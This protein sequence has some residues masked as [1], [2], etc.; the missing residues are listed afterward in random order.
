MHDSL[1]LLQESESKLTYP[2]RNAAQQVSKNLREVDTLIQSVKQKLQSEQAKFVQ[3]YH[4]ITRDIENALRIPII[5]IP[6]PDIEIMDECL[7]IKNIRIVDDNSQSKI[8]LA[9]MSKLQYPSIISQN[10]KPFVDNGKQIVRDLTSCYKELEKLYTDAKQNLA[11]TIPKES[12]LHKQLREYQKIK[13][14]KKYKEE[15]SILEE[16]LDNEVQKLGDMISKC[17]EHN[18]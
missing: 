12:E 10:T 7:V 11:A 13:K 16:Y 4:Q 2:L 15:S 3:E 14:K 9:K 8:N 17:S 6:T 18:L 5:D 1:A